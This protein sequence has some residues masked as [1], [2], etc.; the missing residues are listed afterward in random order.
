[1]NKNIEK[2]LIEAE[3]RLNELLPE[4]EER[5]KKSIDNNIEEPDELKSGAT[6]DLEIRRAIK[7]QDNEEFPK[8]K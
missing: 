6:D 3:E 8:S 7:E 2:A 1:M 4:I 5:H